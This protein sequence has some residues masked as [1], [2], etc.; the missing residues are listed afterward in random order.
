MGYE[1]LEKLLIFFVK[2]F[3]LPPQSVVLQ[4]KTELVSKT[5]HVEAAV[6]LTFFF[7]R[8]LGRNP[9]S[10]SNTEDDMLILVPNDRKLQ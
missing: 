4:I 2:S 3:F 1:I 5:S 9:S 7:P 6:A 10:V 8:I